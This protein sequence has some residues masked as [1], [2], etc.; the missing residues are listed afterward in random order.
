MSSN[1]DAKNSGGRFNTSNDVKILVW[2]RAAG[3]CELCGTDLTHDFRIGASMKWGEV[4]HILPASPKGPRGNPEHSEE[5]AEELTNN[6]E[7]LMLLCPGCH[8]RIDRDGEN[9]HETDLSGLHETCLT[10]IRLAASTPGEE[11][12]IPLIVQ[13]QHFRTIASIPAQALL[14]A[15]SAEGLTAQGHPVYVIFPEPGIRGRDPH[16]WQM[17]KDMITSKLESG[18]MR[19]GGQFGDLPTL[20]LVGLADIP[21]LIFLGQTI[22]DRCRR[23]LFSFNREHALRWPDQQALP[24]RYIASAIPETHGPV[25]LVLSLSA[26][27]PLQDVYATLPDARIV[28]FTI[29]EP[30]YGM[31]T[32]RR[33]IHAFR[34]ELQKKLSELE[35]ITDEP[36]HVFAAV[37]AVIA[38]EFG[39]LLTTQH[40]HPYI[41]YDRDSNSQNKFRPMLTI[42]YPDEEQQP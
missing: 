42:G 12:A 6:S 37:P 2:I 9:Y 26:T 28:Q 41:I 4:A 25:T 13:S 30:G 24:P 20:A 22:G 14:T 31:V 40:Q 3:H 15:M 17:I 38:I 19:R 32:N 34:D 18:L 27:I 7:N 35:A 33:V 36:I 16:Y 11:R 23:S 1:T 39:A 8:D 10:R 21:A 29:T 5:M